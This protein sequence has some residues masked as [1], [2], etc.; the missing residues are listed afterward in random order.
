MASP[1]PFSEIFSGSG[2]VFFG[3]LATGAVI[4]VTFC[5]EKL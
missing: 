3:G 4:A 2:L 1:D 5:I